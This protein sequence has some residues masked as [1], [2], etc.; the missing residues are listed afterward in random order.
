MR[1]ISCP[2]D[3]EPELRL[4]SS[5]VRNERMD[6][7]WPAWMISLHFAP[8]QVGELKTIDFGGSGTSAWLDLL[9][10]YAVCPIG[11]GLLQVGDKARASPAEIWRIRITCRKKLW[12][13]YM[14]GDT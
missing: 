1:L 2:G 9:S 12:D 10:V 13:F 4:K 3:A 8:F 7:P 11:V 6:L 5:S 14:K